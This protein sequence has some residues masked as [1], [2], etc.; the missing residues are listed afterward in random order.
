M[1]FLRKM[2]GKTNE[3]EKIYVYIFILSI[4]SGMVY[5]IANKD[6][7]KCCETVLDMQEGDNAGTIFISNLFLSVTNLIT[8]GVSSIFINFHTFSITS[9]FFYTQ[10]TLFALPFLFVHGSFEI[11]GVMLFGLNGLSLF[12]KKI[13]KRKS[14]LKNLYL[15]AYGTIFLLIGSLIEIGLLKLI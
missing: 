7:Y 5:G 10:G 12:Q 15:L 14:S 4:L 13:L 1:Q 6:Y 3:I 11:F 8:A 9:S 2:V